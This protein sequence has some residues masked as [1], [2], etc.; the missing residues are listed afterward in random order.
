MIDSEQAQPNVTFAPWRNVRGAAEYLCLSE[1]AVRGLVKRRQLPCHR[2]QQ[3]HVR[4]HVEELD[5]WARGD[6][7]SA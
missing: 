5:A 4:F 1:D 6:E 3:G 7:L 2:S